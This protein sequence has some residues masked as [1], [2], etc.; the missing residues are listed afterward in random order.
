MEVPIMLLI[1]SCRI[2][3]VSLALTVTYGAYYTSFAVAPLATSQ[4]TDFV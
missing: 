1:K 2:T 4:A 3:K